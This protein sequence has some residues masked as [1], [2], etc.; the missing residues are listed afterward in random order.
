MERSIDVQ[1]RMV[2]AVW[3]TVAESTTKGR[4]SV[5]RN[6]RIVPKF[7][8]IIELFIATIVRTLTVYCAPS[9]I[10]TLL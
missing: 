4:S 3:A 8:V 10:I 6:N 9:E 2:S 1:T 7:W 5:D